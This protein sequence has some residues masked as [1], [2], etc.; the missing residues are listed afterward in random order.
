MKIPITELKEKVVAILERSFNHEDAVR[1]ADYFMWAEM[2]GNRTQ[3][4][5][6]MTGTEPLQSIKPKSEIKVVRD[7]K[8]VAAH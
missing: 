3:G 7:K 2:S 6:K 5:L 8:A 4:L 1:I